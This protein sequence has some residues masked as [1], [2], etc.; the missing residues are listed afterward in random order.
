MVAVQL[1]ASATDAYRAGKLDVADELY[2][3]DYV[4]HVGRGPEGSRVVGPEGIKQ[5]VMLFRRGF[6]DLTY[7][8][9]EE[10]AE[11]D[12]VWTR[13]FARGTH[14]GEFLGAAPTGRI[15]TYT[16]MDLN[17]ITDGR[18]VESWVNY[19]ALALLEQVGLVAPIKGM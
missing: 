18:I 3:R 6:P 17:R 8:V 1:L 7:T 19:D 11:R 12:L 2:A 14:Q 15:V 9:E 4:D 13:F 10:M 5:A 16:G